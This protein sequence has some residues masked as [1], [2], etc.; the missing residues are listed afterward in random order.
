MV[1]NMRN[2][3][4]YIIIVAVLLMG[5]PSI[6]PAQSQY[7]NE[8]TVSLGAGS[9]ALK[10]QLDEGPSKSGFGWELGVGY[11]HYFSRTVGFSIGLEA[12]KFGSSVEVK[13]ISYEQE[14][15]TP[16]G[17]SGRFLLQTNYNGLKE[18]QSAVLL[19]IPLL[20]Q[21][22]FPVSEKSFFFLGTGIKAGF[23]ASS[24]WNQSIATL[25]TT[26][27][28]EYTGQ[29]Y[30]NMQNHGFS[31]RFDLSASGKLELKSAVLLALEG[32]FKLAI[33]EGKYLYTGLFLDYGLNDMYKVSTHTTLLEYNNASPANYNF[34]SILTTSHYS[35]PEGIKPFAVGIKMK[36]GFGGGK[37]IDP[38]KKTV[39]PIKKTVDPVRKTVSPKE[40]KMEPVGD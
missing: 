19:Q 10:Y 22:Q 7:D 5:Y 13:D 28:S 17:L 25:T 29:H 6:L 34:Q 20:L 21:F 1:K 23:P 9:S 15:Q 33:S 24:K 11:S 30:A 4:E 14:I 8:F 27:Y 26:G 3:R 37:A 12:K 31:T 32:G 18:K 35:V 38:I 2:L 40:Q 36:I 16:P 39:D